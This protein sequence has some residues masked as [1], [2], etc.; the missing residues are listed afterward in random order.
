[1]LSAL[2]AEDAQKLCEELGDLLMQIGMHV[3]IATEGGEFQFADVIG[4][5]DAKLKRRHPHVFGDLIVE[6]TGEVL[7]TWE[8]I[9][10]KERA[11]FEQ[12]GELIS[13]LDS[14]PAILPA[15]AR[16]QALGERAARTGFDWPD[17]SGVLDKVSEELAELID[18]QDQ[19][20]RARELGDLFFSLVN[21]ARWLRI[22]AESALRGACDRFSK[23][24]AHM[25]R[26]AQSQGVDLAGLSPAE[27]DALWNQAKNHG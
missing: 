16:A 8:A 3:Q 10:A 26:D 15:L 20:G 11:N 24:Y 25:E 23:R 4:G 21:V 27:Q 1:V 14:V 18:C 22:D 12:D 2:D 13:S 5:I 9:K 17:L 7:R 6:S 19:L